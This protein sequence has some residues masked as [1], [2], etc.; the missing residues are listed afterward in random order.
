ML[1]TVEV[2][3]RS[4][5]TLSMVFGRRSRPLYR[6]PGVQVLLCPHTHAEQCQAVTVLSLIDALEGSSSITRRDGAAVPLPSAVPYSLRAPLTLG[7]EALWREMAPEALAFIDEPL[8][9][10]LH[11]TALRCHAGDRLLKALFEP[12]GYAVEVTHLAGAEIG[13]D[14]FDSI[15]YMVRLSGSQT[16]RD[17]LSHVSVVV[18]SLDVHA[19]QWLTEMDVERV[20]QHGF[21]WIA[22]HPQRQLIET[23]L[24]GESPPEPAGLH[25]E[26]HRAVRDHLIA[27]G[28]K[29]VLDLG[30]GRGDLVRLLVREPCF[31]E[32]AAIDISAEGI[33]EASINWSDDSSQCRVSFQQRAL[34]Y[35]DPVFHGFD[36]AAVVEVIEHLGE[37]QLR[38]FERVIWD[39]ARPTTIIVTTPNFE[40][41]A[42]LYPGSPRLRE[43]EH[44]FEWTRPQFENWARSLAA[45]TGY[46]VV[47]TGAGPTDGERGPLTQIAIFTRTEPV[48]PSTR[49]KPACASY[50]EEVLESSVVA[51]GRRIST[52]FSR[53]LEI[54]F[55]GAAVALEM[56]G[57]AAVDPRWLIYLPHDSPSC[58]PPDQESLIE[59]PADAFDYFERNGVRRVVCIETLSRARAVCIVCRD[60]AAAERRFGVEGQGGILYGF[61]GRR[62]FGSE[63]FQ[64]AVLRAA[65]AALDAA[66]FWSRFD[67]DWVALDCEVYPWSATAQSVVHGRPV[68]LHSFMAPAITG[69]VSLNAAGEILGRAEAAGELPGLS[70][71]VQQRLA[72]VREYTALYRQHWSP[73]TAVSDLRLLPLDVLA[74]EGCVH[75]G[76]DALWHLEE[77]RRLAGEFPGLFRIPRH[78]PFLTDAAG[79]AAAVEWMGAL[80]DRSREGFLLKPL[81]TAPD[82]VI[83]ELHPSLRCGRSTALWA[84]HCSERPSAGAFA[85][86]TERGN[87]AEALLALQQD[88][89]SREAL[90]RFVEGQ[91]L[92]RVHE[93]V[94]AALSTQCQVAVVPSATGGGTSR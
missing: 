60:T 3:P 5:N 74:T 65:R 23:R 93:C 73:V 66:E 85:R 9:L 55:E 43:P 11:L 6:G 7:I 56:I 67:T 77:G 80:A 41:N 39:R 33:R 63:A 45:R 86:L 52:R 31:E 38:A 78:E 71:Q 34:S 18:A 28:A 59:D 50:G 87:R 84:K 4:A 8:S 79:R 72:S 89:L 70:T 25:G 14:G 46:G 48:L 17:A 91:P 61:T 81:G 16:L 40:Y 54:P 26:R 20:L 88:L 29:R 51:A 76:R 1:L 57:S 69:Q 15:H 90:E 13:V 22:N 75:L 2:D 82:T 36:A 44:R 53:E 68:S 35:A 47:F 37:H 83:G 30:C 24:R 10:S 12:L 27:L 64:A 58:R 19:G 21:S 92:S 49:E 42:L 94:F 32:I 62:A